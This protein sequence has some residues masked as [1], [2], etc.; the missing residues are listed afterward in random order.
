MASGSSD[1]GSS[2]GSE[3]QVVFLGMTTES[4]FASVS[5]H[6]SGEREPDKNVG[7]VEA[8]LISNHVAS[9]HSLFDITPWAQD[10]NQTPKTAG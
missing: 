10:Y 8:G 7:G 3:Q 2:S 6:P 1:L 9:L 4:Y 5:L